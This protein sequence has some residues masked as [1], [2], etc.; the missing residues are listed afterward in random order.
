MTV[1]AGDI[2]CMAEVYRTMEQLHEFLRFIL[3]LSWTIF[4]L[5]FKHIF[6]CVHL[7][8]LR[9]LKGCSYWH[10]LY[11]SAS[12]LNFL[13]TDNHHFYLTRRKKQKTECEMHTCK[14]LCPRNAIAFWNDWLSDRVNDSMKVFVQSSA[15]IV[16]TISASEKYTIIIFYSFNVS[17]QKKPTVRCSEH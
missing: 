10:A 5:F 17:F 15:D 9:S 13:L 4:L 3:G 11:Y 16:I 12:F 1:G 7:L 6:T 2:S 8:L 14:I